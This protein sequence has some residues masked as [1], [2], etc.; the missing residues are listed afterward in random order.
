MQKSSDGHYFLHPRPGV[1]WLSCILHV[2]WQDKD[3]YKDVLIV[4][5]TGMETSLEFGLRRPQC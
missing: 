3:W 4:D 5:V 2:S 1:F